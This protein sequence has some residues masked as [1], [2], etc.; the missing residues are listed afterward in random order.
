M[1][2]ERRYLTNNTTNPGTDGVTYFDADT[3]IDNIT[4]GSPAVNSTSFTECLGF[5]FRPGSSTLDSTNVPIAVNIAGFSGTIEAR[6]RM[7][8]GATRYAV[9][10]TYTT[11][12][13]KSETLTLT[14]VTSIASL[15]NVGLFVEIRRSGGH[16]NVDIVL[17]LNAGVSY[18]DIDYTPITY[19]RAWVT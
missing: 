12:G 9:G 4:V 8:I 1:S 15:T 5:I 7:G 2:V 14:G 18:F 17:N 19:K 11:T 16:G 10:A 3:T 13:T 6:F